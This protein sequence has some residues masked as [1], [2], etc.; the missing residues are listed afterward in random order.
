MKTSKK[1]H[2]ELSPHTIKEEDSSNNRI[3]FFKRKNY[4]TKKKKMNNNN[5]NINNKIVLKIK[6]IKIK[7][8]VK[9]HR[10][11]KKYIR[12]NKKTRLKMQ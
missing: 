1:A 11:Q 10:K 2:S 4:Q 8:L 5:N 3:T 9:A 7:N 12:K 6:I